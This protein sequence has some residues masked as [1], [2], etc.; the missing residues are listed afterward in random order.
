MN[1][2]D[3]YPPKKKELANPLEISNQQ[4]LDSAPLRQVSGEEL[5]QRRSHK[6]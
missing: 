3:P 6:Q 2:V 4:F 5:Y 1:G